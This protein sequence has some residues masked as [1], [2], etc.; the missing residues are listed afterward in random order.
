MKRLGLFVSM[1]TL[2]TL[3]LPAVAQDDRPPRGERQRFGQRIP[4][5]KREL[6]WTW[7]AKGV[8]KQIELNDEKTTKLVEAYV[9]SRKSLQESMQEFRRSMRDAR[10]T[11]EG[12]GRGAGRGGERG[13]GRGGGQG[14]QDIRQE[15]RSI[16]DAEQK[17]FETAVAAFLEDES[18]E[19]AVKTLGSFSGQWDLL[20]VGLIDLKLD[21]EKMYASLK[22]VQAYAMKIEKAR[23]SDERGAMRDAM[24][25]GLK[26][27]D[28]ALDDILT[29]EQMKAFKDSIRPQRG[30]RGGRP[31]GGRGLDGPP[32]F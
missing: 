1:L 7:E 18:L 10:G 5:E 29:E 17:K 4:D 30:R 20:V 13:A 21:D 11:G 22:P 23:E 31:G 12:R 27:L 28:D 19:T 15:M 2:A 32:A 9:A 26:E 24:Q 8:A 16:R 14:A 25:D 3:C 6:A